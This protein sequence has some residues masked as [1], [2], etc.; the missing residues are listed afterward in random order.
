MG[1]GPS[2][3]DGEDV[4]DHYNGARTRGRRIG[5]PVAPARGR[6]VIRV[7]HPA[8]DA[9]LAAERERGPALLALRDACRRGRDAAQVVVPEGPARPAGRL[10]DQ[11][12]LT[13]NRD[14][15]GASTLH[16]SSTHRV[17]DSAG[18]ARDIRVWHELVTHSPN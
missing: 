13:A 4:K 12:S 5:D 1:R 17:V 8:L 6:A 15:P 2:V 18:R 14:V 16:V 11:M 9:A 7:G 10:A 3:D